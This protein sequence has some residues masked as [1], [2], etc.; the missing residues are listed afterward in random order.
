MLGPLPPLM[1]QLLLLRGRVS[2]C[3]GSFAEKAGALHHDCVRSCVLVEKNA[4]K[5]P[6]LSLKS[7]KH[8]QITNLDVGAQDSVLRDRCSVGMRHAFLSITSLSI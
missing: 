1:C 8:R 4:S 5:Q 7:F 2:Q 6:N 3:R